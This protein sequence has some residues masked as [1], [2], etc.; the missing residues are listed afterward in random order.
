MAASDE[1]EQ[2]RSSLA[3]DHRS[4][5]LDLL[6]PPPDFRLDT[7][8]TTTFTLDLE[9]ALVA[10]LAFA[11]FDSSG[12]GDPIAALEAIR[13]VAD[14]LT[15]FCQ[16]GEIRVPQA[17]SDLFAFLEPVVHEVRRPK[18]GHLFHPK[19]WLLR[20]VNDDGAHAMRL[21]VPTRNLTNDASW[22]AVLRLDGEPTGGPKAANRPIADL[23]RW[24][25]TNTSQRIDR[26][27]RAS[28]DAL[29]ESLRRTTWDHPDGVT[30][31]Q[32]H[33]LGIGRSA[34][35]DFRGN[36]HLV[37]SPFVNDDGIEFVAPSEDV[38]LISRP[39][40]MEL[41]STELLERI[42]CRWF[43]TLDFEGAEDTSPLGDL[44]AKL[45]ITE[46]ARRAY[47]FV[48]SA[49]ATGA[50]FGGNVEVLVE[51]RG[52]PAA[53]GIDAVLGDLGKVV[54]PCTIHGGQELG[55][56]DELRKQLD[57]L[58]RDAALN[59]LELRA[60]PEA[61]GL[62]T[63]RLAGPA[64]L[65]S[66][67]PDLSMSVE[68]LSRPGYAIG[69]ASA[70]PPAGAFTGVPIADITPF[71]VLRVTLT[72]PTQAVTGSCVLRARLVDDPPGRFDAVIARQ[73]DTPAKFLRFLFLLLGMS[74]GAIPAWLQAAA[75][76]E[77]GDGS[78]TPR[79]LVELGVFEALTRALVTNPAALDD[80]GRLVERLHAT[81]E[82]RRTLPDGFDE[83]WRALDTA[84]QLTD[85]TP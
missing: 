46:Y 44:H 39:E 18:P 19:L 72:G 49:N 76:S 67:E 81:P 64:P 48:G 26:T 57:A 69:I 63:L 15:V 30:E 8:V 7:A 42:D 32:F 85:A 12:P 17:A 55:E 20:Y 37:V 4:V 84:R 16:G 66:G 61:E 50:A 70:D 83:L 28:L 34:L 68:L 13:T 29:V 45:V 10:P 25:M 73:V 14:R 75:N 54:E 22:D 1:G 24:C 79:D 41:L 52:S 9:A 60:E 33:A 35:P 53:H 78:L 5:L 59:P 31:I 74:G 2:R 3:P 82:G 51:L 56:A 40:Q 23:V 36:R 80:L 38:T 71:L 62:W 21:L 43:A 27:R 11:A 65:A 77:N 6:R 47:L 58:L